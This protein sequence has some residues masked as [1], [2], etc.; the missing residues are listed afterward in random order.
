MGR[1]RITVEHGAASLTAKATNGAIEVELPAYFSGHSDGATGIGKVRSEFVLSGNSGDS[2]HVR[3][4]LGTGGSA[5]VVLRTT[6]GDVRLAKRQQP[7]N[8]GTRTCTYR[9]AIPARGAPPR[10]TCVIAVT[11]MWESHPTVAIP[12]ASIPPRADLA[13]S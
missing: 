5:S 10:L 2:R 3:G 9:P 11:P 1:I 12:S 13:R 8:P 6:N 4:M 7:P